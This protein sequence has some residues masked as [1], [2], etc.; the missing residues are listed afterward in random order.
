MSADCDGTRTFA[1]TAELVGTATKIAAGGSTHL[2]EYRQ[3]AAKG[4]ERGS[5]WPPLLYLAA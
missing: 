2:P 1:D 3:Y 4:A 5:A